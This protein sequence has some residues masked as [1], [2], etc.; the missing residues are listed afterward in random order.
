MVVK[1]ESVF[2]PKVFLNMADIGRTIEKRAI[3]ETIFTQ[4][5]VSDA[6]FYVM[7]GKLKLSVVS[8]QGK[9]AVVGIL[10]PDD[11][12]GEACLAGQTRRNSSATAI[13]KSEVMRMEKKA[14][15]RVLHEEPAF[16]ELFI[17][18]LLARMMRVEEDLVDQLFNS[19]E[20]RLARTLLLLADAGRAGASAP[21]LGKLSQE[22]LADMVGTTRPRVNLFMN[23]FRRLGFI[24]YKNGAVTVNR[25]LL[26]LM[27]H[28][29]VQLKS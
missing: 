26:D 1:A 20:K 24:D 12:C 14:I 25:S 19:S 27:L 15:M 9:D 3:D 21:I 13:A 8:E 2:D 4:G 28:D 18:H 11:F 23:K 7:S 16:S 17:E 22:T 10:S 6:V 29:D 5:D